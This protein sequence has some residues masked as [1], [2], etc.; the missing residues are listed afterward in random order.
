MLEATIAALANKAKKEGF[1]NVK[2]I[3]VGIKILLETKH[4]V[5]TLEKIKE[6][7]HFMVEGSNERFKE[8][9]EIIIKGATWGTSAILVDRIGYDLYIE[10]YRFNY[11]G[12]N[13]PI[14]HTSAVKSAKII[15]KN[16]EYEMWE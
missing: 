11:D 16:F 1:I 6:P 13:T 3:P 5:Y 14:L 9:Q 8:P 4:N 10:I 2:E 15:G 12:D 7:N